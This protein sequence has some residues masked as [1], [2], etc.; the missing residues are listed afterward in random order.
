MARAEKTL[1]FG[2]GQAG[3]LA[4]SA[5][6]TLNS[7]RQ[8]IENLEKTSVSIKNL[9]ENNS[10]LGYQVNKTLE[11]ISAMARTLRSLADYLEQHPEALIRGK[12]LPKGE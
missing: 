3:K 4:A 5:Q 11:D 1:S 12:K 10:T 7:A 6:E 2:E 9:A 8:L